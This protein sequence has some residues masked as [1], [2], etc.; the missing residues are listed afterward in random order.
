MYDKMPFLASFFRIFLP[1]R[2]IFNI[3][4]V[5]SDLH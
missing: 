2:S 4:N 5:Y 1:A 3:C